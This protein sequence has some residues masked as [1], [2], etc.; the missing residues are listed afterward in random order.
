[1]FNKKNEENTLTLILAYDNK[2]V[3][4]GDENM[5]YLYFVNNL[6]VNIYQKKNT[7]T[8]DVYYKRTEK[9]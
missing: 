3:Y 7:T 6:Y 1:M 9:K 8:L 5:V 2:N 4:D